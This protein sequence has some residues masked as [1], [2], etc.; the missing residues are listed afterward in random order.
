MITKDEER[1]MARCLQSIRPVVDEIVVVDTGS[2]DRT[3]EIAGLW[4]AKIYDFKWT[5]DFSKARN[6]SLSKASG[7]WIFSLDADEVVSA[8]DHGQFLRLVREVPSTL[9]AY[10]FVTRNYTADSNPVG[11]V[12]NDGKYRREESGCGW[13]ATEKVRLF[14]NRGRIQYDYAVHEMVEPSLQRACIEIRDCNIPIHHYGALVE[15]KNNLKMQTYYRMGRKKLDF[16]GD[17]LA[18]LYELAVQAAILGKTTEAVEIWEKFLALKTDMPEAF[19]HLATAYI[20]RK[21][22]RSALKVIKKALEIDPEMK[23]AIYNYCLCEFIIGDIHNTIRCLTH[24]LDQSPEFLPA[25]L[26][27]AAAHI[28]AGNIQKGLKNFEDLE[29]TEMRSSLG[30][31]FKDL[32]NRLSDQNR[33]DYARLLQT[34]ILKKDRFNSR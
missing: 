25:K 12:A 16:L 18:A 29:H 34:S 17:N 11:W 19:V 4:G 6:Y 23:E 9:R 10:S 14:P 26:V 7:S 1:F 27:L 32:A 5:G 8:C 3:A 2:Q 20:Q 31:T 33:S 22:Y 24:L 15:D 21:D 28:C 13:V 30:A